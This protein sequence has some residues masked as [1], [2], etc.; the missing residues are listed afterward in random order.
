MN[1]VR[2]G[3]IGP[4][5]IAHNFVNAVNSVENAKVVGCASK[6]I[7]RARKFAKEY[8][9]KCFDT[10]EDLVKS[11]EIDA[12]YIATTHNFHYENMLLCIENGKHVLCEKPFTLNKTQADFVFERARLNKVFVMEAMWVRF[13]PAYKWAKKHIDNGAIG[14]PVS[15]M[16]SLGEQFPFDKDSR[17]FNINLAGGGVLDIGIYPL[18]VTSMFFGSEP[19]DIKSVVHIGETGVDYSGSVSLVYGGGEIASICYTML[20]NIDNKVV[21][22][23]T[24]GKIVINNIFANTGAVLKVKNVEVLFNETYVNGFIN[25]VT[26]ATERILSGELESPVMSWRDT[27]NIMGICDK[28]RYDVKFYYPEESPDSIRLN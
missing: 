3:I 8:E 22:C 9:L 6:T 19:V 26:E 24:D 10:Y 17:A 12:V 14:K 25:Q 18:S 4:G 7:S 11:N 28:I 20:A 27:S 2:W 13:L 23:G 15:I 5:R 21:I 1:V 16:A